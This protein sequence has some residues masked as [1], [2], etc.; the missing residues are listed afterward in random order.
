MI[1]LGA[2]EQLL[3][4]INIFLMELFFFDVLLQV[5]KKLTASC[6]ASQTVQM[7]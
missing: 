5:K 4:L 2:F 7:S 6:K 3:V 1:F